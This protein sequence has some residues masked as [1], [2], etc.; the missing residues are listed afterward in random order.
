[1]FVSAATGVEPFKQRLRESGTSFADVFKDEVQRRGHSILE[2]HTGSVSGE[3]LPLNTHDSMCMY[4]AAQLSFYLCHLVY[5]SDILMQ[6]VGT[7]HSFLTKV[8]SPRNGRSNDLQQTSINPET[9]RLLSPSTQS[10][11]PSYSSSRSVGDRDEECLD[12]SLGKHSWRIN[13][14]RIKGVPL[15]FVFRSQPRNHKVI[16]QREHREYSRDTWS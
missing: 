1:M 12:Y 8:T 3:E 15:S 9:K 14:G 5:Y 4:R 10:L 16:L 7:T 13:S 6:L 2:Q 11:C